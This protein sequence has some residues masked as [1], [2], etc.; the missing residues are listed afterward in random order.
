MYSKFKNNEISEQD[1][2]NYKKFI[3]S[4]L[5]FNIEIP[6]D[7]V[8]NYNHINKIT[9]DIEN[10][11]NIKIKD[12]NKENGMVLKDL[13]E[14]NNINKNNIKNKAQYILPNPKTKTSD[15]ENKKLILNFYN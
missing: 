11:N 1:F 15:E 14:E 12:N 7:V 9:E 10:D 8:D 4:S 5:F 2:E 3:N 13:N 6:E